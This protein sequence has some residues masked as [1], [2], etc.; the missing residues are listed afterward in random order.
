[1]QPMTHRLTS[2]L[3][4]LERDSHDACSSCGRSFSDGDTA[5]TAYNADGLPFY[6][7]NSCVEQIRETAVRYR[8]SARA[9]ENPQPETTM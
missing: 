2:E 5:H 9:Y 3:R 4:K 1:M 6:V 8:W 7:G